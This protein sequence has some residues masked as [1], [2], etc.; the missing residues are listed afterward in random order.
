MTPDQV[1][2]NLIDILDQAAGK[3]HSR[4]GSVVQCLADILT[5]YLAVLLKFPPEEGRLLRPGELLVIRYEYG[6][7]ND[8]DFDRISDE[9]SAV[10]PDLAFILTDGDSVKIEKAGHADAREK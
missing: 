7:L 1:P 2:Q 10:F 9:L 5:E 6:R 8:A 4:T 3:K